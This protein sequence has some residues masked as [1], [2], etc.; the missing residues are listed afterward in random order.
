MY[1]T[2]IIYNMEQQSYDRLYVICIT[3]IGSTGPR[4]VC[5][6]NTSEVKGRKVEI[7]YERENKRNQSNNTIQQTKWRRLNRKKRNTKI[8]IK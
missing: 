2:G 8:L 1:G 6:W 3:R 7:H 5:Y 4:V